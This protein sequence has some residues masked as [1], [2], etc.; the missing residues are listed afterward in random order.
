MTYFLLQ[1]RHLHA[2]GNA[3]PSFPGA[4]TAKIR[5]GPEDAFGVANSQSRTT[6]KRAAPAHLLWNANE[7][8]SV[9]QGDLIDALDAALQLGALNA[10][11][12]G[13]TLEL[14]IGVNSLKEAEQVVGSASQLLPAFLSLRLQVFVWIKEFLVDIAESRSRLETSSHRSGI[15]IATTE[16]NENAATPSGAGAIGRS[17]SGRSTKR[18]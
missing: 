12:V 16:H 8:T 6:A 13:N 7:G 18:H 5:F 14:R 4:L 11:W 2:L 10:H 9:W 3:P 1:H 17:S 15:T